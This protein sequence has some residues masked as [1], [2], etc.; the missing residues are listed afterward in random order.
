[1]AK[2]KVDWNKIGKGISSTGTYIAENKK[3]LLYVGGAVAVVVIGWAVVNRFKKA[4]KGNNIKGGKFVKQD[5]DVE[6]LTITPQ[7]AKNYAEA[8]YSAF[9]YYWGTDKSIINNVFDK[10]SPE[11]FKLI[12]NEFGVRSRGVIDGKE[13]TAFEKWLKQYKDLDL[14]GWLNAELDF[15][16]FNL[17]KK[18]RAIV[19][20]AGFILD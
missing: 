16:D 20:P 8:L 9:T 15:L 17:K 12:S 10:I 6:K 1:M 5:I 4:V 3:P 2:S 13:P 7:I 11:D 18:V 19:E 14:I